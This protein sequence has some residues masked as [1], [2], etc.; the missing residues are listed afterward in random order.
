MCTLSFYP[1]ADNDGFILTFSRDEMSAR[2]SVEVVQDE[3][4]GLVYPKDVLHGGTWLA[5]SKRNGRLTCLL[6]GAFERHER[7]LPYRKS[8]GLVLLES[9]DY[10]D[11]LDFFEDYDFE[12]I[13][14]FT[15][16]TFQNQQIFQFRWDGNQRYIEKVDVQKPLLKSSCTL[17]NQVVRQERKAW[18]FDFLK[19][20]NNNIEAKNLWQFHKTTNEEAPEKSI[21]MRR[22]LGPSTVS[23]TQLNY[24]FS[25]QLIDFQYY[26][27]GK[28]DISH[29]QF[30]YGTTVLSV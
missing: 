10:A 9:F 30:T 5:L 16:L 11:M 8:R 15:L 23:I 22:P 6:N 1:K 2:S 24:S 12:N 13:E 26:E 29:C 17:Y 20:K 18:F 21:L 19:Q 4:R 3:Q 25:S 27:L 14:P 28:Q 7:I